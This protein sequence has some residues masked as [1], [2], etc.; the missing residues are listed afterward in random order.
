VPTDRLTLRN[1]IHD[2]KFTHV[3]SASSWWSAGRDR[4]ARRGFMSGV[5]K[6]ANTQGSSASSLPPSTNTSP[7][8][9]MPNA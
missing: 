1:Q 5:C 2:V 9:M 6:A 3:G 4:D 7:L 8:F